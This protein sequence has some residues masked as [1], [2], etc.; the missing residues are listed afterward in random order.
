MAEQR[1]IFL[2]DGYKPKPG[3]TDNRGYQAAPGKVGSSVK[4]P[5]PPAQATS[6][7][8]KPVS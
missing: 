6:V 8:K 3:A 2:S 4:L 5:K 7:V 1:R